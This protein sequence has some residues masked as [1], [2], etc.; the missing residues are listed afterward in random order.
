MPKRFLREASSVAS[1]WNAADVED[2]VQ[3]ET[4]TRLQ[5]MAAR[6]MAKYSEEGRKRLTQPKVM[7]RS[8]GSA[9]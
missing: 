3:G 8:L 2:A 6:R 7:I 1:H 4:L 5:E 9:R